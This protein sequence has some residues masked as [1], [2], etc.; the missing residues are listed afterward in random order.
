MS[1]AHDKYV[2]RQQQR[3]AVPLALN[4]LTSALMIIDMQEYFLNSESPSR[5]PWH[6]R[7]RVSVIICRNVHAPSPDQHCAVYSKAFAPVVYQ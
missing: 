7:C 2:A 5:A 3:N 1:V 6:T 4:P